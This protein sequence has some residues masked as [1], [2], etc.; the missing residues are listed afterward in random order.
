M[1]YLRGK[2]YADH[3]LFIVVQ[4]EQKGASATEYGFVFGIFELVVFLV[5]PYYGK[6]VSSNGEDTDFENRETFSNKT[7]FRKNII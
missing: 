2:G 7:Q 4:A 6:K 3:D 5:S 1:R